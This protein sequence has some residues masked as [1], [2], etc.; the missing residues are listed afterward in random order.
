MVKVRVLDDIQDTW[1]K[2]AQ[3]EGTE[4]LKGNLEMPC[5]VGLGRG[6]QEDAL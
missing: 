2:P 6:V 1:K 4:K 5:H 3:D